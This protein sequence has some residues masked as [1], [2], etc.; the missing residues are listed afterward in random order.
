MTDS[1]SGTPPPDRLPGDQS[2]TGRPDAGAPVLVLA[3]ASAGSAETAEVAAVL[4]RLRGLAEVEVA[5]PGRDGELSDLVA[6]AAGRAVV[7]VGGDGSLNGVL[8]A[9]VER[10]VLAAVGP[11]GLVPLG[12]GN[13]FARGHGVPLDP[14]RAAQVALT[15]RT[16]SVGLLHDDQGRVVVNVVHVGVAAEAT[17][18]AEDVKGL[19]GR[20]GY[21]VGAVRAGIGALGW[22]L[23]VLVDDEVVLD[24][25]SRTLMVSVALG[26]SVGGGTPVAPTAAPEDGLADVVVCTATG[27]AARLGFA[28]DLRAGRHLGRADVR[29]LRG[30]RVHVEALAG[31]SF[32]INA[33]GDLVG[34]RRR[35]TWTLEPQAWRIRT[36]G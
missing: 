11:V 28:R 5:V 34:R 2:P 18:H 10:D 9:M 27:W 19:L 20:T 22:R 24:G 16:R 12:T 36:A 15:G 35:S 29:V 31:E 23:R 17:A 30:R 32:G 26:R 6:G 8:Q 13:D 7:V 33:D 14:Q 1:T 3:N 21:L 25:G 4:R